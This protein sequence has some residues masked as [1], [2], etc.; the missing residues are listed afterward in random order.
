MKKTLNIIS[1]IAILIVGAAVWAIY[2]PAVSSASAG[3]PIIFEDF[4]LDQRQVID[5]SANAESATGTEAEAVTPREELDAQRKR[6]DQLR[7]WSLLTVISATG[8]SAQELNQSLY[9]MPALRHDSLRRVSDF[10]YGETRSRVIGDGQVIALIPVSSA[11]QR[12]DHL[13][14]IA[15]E[16]RKSTGEIPNTFYVFEY[17][18]HPEEDFASITRRQVI[19]GK[20]LF[21]DEY[22]YVELLVRNLDDFRHLM[23]SIDDITFAR[24]TDSGL[25]FGG[26]K[27]KS[28]HYRGIR[29]EDIAGVWRSE[30][31]L[32]GFGS[33]GFSLDTQIDLERVSKLFDKEI[34]PM[35]QVYAGLSYADTQKLKD[36]LNEIEKNRATMLQQDKATFLLM[37]QAYF[38][39]TLA[40]LCEG[41]SDA[42]KRMELAG[43]IF[44]GY[45]FMA[46]TYFGELQGTEVG[47]ALF[48]TDLLM[49]LWLFDYMESTPRRIVGFPIKTEMKVSAIYKNELDELPGTRFWLSSLDRG[50]Q[51]GEGGQTLLFARNATGV[52]ARPHDFF[53]GRDKPESSEPDVFSRTFINWWNDHYEE[54]ARYEPEYER[55]NQIM[56]WSQVVGWLNSTQKGDLLSFLEPVDIVRT[57]RFTSWVQQHPELT[58]KSWDK[59]KFLEPGHGGTSTEALE[60]LQSKEFPFFGK[61]ISWSGGVSLAGRATFAERAALSRSIATTARR[62]NLDYRLSD[63]TI[64]R[65]RTLEATEFRFRSFMQEAAETLAR[66][67]PNTRLR[68]EV[69]ELTNVEIHRVINRTSDGLMV[70]TRALG[71]DFGNLSIARTARGYKVGWQSRD[72]DLGQS[73]ARRISTSATPEELLLR[74]PNLESIIKL[75]GDS[76]YLVKARGTD[77]WIKIAAQ[78]SEGSTVAQGFQYRV[79]GLSDK[80]KRIDVAWL[81]D[82]AVQNELQGNAFLTISGEQGAQSGIRMTLGLRGPSATAQEIRLTNGNIVLKVNVDPQTKTIY[83]RWQDL[84]STVRNHP[85]RIAEMIKTGR[86]ELEQPYLRITRELEARA[87]SEAARDLA[88]DPA[89][90][91]MRLN[92]HLTEELRHNNEL[93]LK[94]Q[95]DVAK[96]HVDDLVSIHGNLPELKLRQALLE[97][98]TKKV[99]R[100]VAK[101]QQSGRESLNNPKAFFDEINHRL[102][103]QTLSA[104]ERSNLYNLARRTDW[105]ES[106]LKSLGEMIPEAR[107]NSLVLRL[108]IEQVPKG[109]IATLDDI[110]R[111]DAVIYIQDSPG[112]HNIDVMPSAMNSTLRPLISANRV[113]IR[114]ALLKDLAYFRPATIYETQTRTALRLSNGNSVGIK[115]PNIYRP[116]SS[117]DNVGDDDEED[118]E[119]KKRVYIVLENRPPMQRQ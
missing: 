46:A 54:I 119:K 76:A 26:R 11:E 4:P 91:R 20:E 8:L 56:K 30:R 111:N 16:Q 115:L 75:P 113:V 37:S 110:A 36:A 108:Q 65:L 17:E 98:S 12:A 116:I 19:S 52:F 40:K 102:A 104:Q 69:G 45:S 80:A 50:F 88:R 81:D 106:R 13:A 105:Y 35:L 14:H 118:E 21:T 63:L 70:Q 39:E 31:G 78:Q 25:I 117:I 58:F 87:Y 92:Q 103:N 95:F 23:A 22:G 93:L 84:P 38:V 5:F 60:I 24:S 101:L 41:K 33:S 29:V 1:I 49:K 79:A 15:D 42:N 61:P 47:M 53:L 64:G 83:V 3:R 67:K 28:H 68:G 2:T 43:E 18:L 57:N 86:L 77:S 90:F 72:I 6:L 85:A 97:L 7:D 44:W 74:E 66:A 107:G 109:K 32:T 94:Q 10:E 62:A 73:L 48:Y 99:D 114:E 51:V 71:T 96:Q 59:V 100:A 82:V 34:A 9:D 89:G 27:S 112:L 55:L